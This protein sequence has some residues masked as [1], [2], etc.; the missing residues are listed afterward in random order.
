MSLQIGIVGL[1]NVGKS[2]LFKALTKIQVDAS[3][4]PFCTIDPNV[5]VVPVPDER[6]QKLADLSHSKKIVPAVIEFVDIAGLVA[7]ASKGEG[8]GNK[9]L[10]NIREVDA[11]VH[12]VREFS[13]KNVI[14][15]HGDVNPKTDIEV[16]NLELMLADLQQ[17]A[18][19]SEKL[20][21]KARGQDKTAVAELAV[22]EKMKAALENGQLANTVE[23]D[24]EKEL[25]LVAH[26]HLLTMKPILYVVNVDEGVTVSKLL[27]EAV[28]ISAKIEAELS[29]LPEEDAK[30]MMQELGMHETG[31]QKLITAGYT[32]LKLQSFLTT[33]EDE[34]RAWPIPQ[35]TKAPQAAGVIHTDFEEKFIR[36]EVIDWKKLI[37][38]GSWSAAR[39][40][41]WLR[42]EGKD[43][44]FQDG[45]VVEIHHS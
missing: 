34:T 3:N 44:I 25:P 14:H 40:K 45:D 42:M 32:L 22:L 36:A 13:D 43:Y 21:K 28:V 1:P 7:G 31:L 37:E 30:V 38:A 5:G 35:G 11:I 4:Y 15:V 24:K 17:I 23:L 27:P 29:E 33:G 6:L 41:G 39:D 2:T 26:H 12:V 9:F 18:N 20:S 16:I 10:A 8:L 19:V